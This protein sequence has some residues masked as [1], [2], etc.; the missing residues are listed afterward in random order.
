MRCGAVRVAILDG[1]DDG[2]LGVG[3]QLVDA[4]A[5][6]VERFSRVMRVMHQSHQF[7]ECVPATRGLSLVGQVGGVGYG[8]EDI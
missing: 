7:G 8:E 5:S 1:A 2:D 6:V 4:A 3:F